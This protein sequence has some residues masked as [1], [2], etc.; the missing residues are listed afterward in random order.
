ML[1]IDVVADGERNVEGR[2]LDVDVCNSLE[3]HVLNLGRQFGFARIDRAEE[4]GIGRV[5]IL[6][7]DRVEKIEPDRTSAENLLSATLFL[8][9]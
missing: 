6:A 7:V 3:N 2:E 1:V 4:L 9:S 8:A 5:A